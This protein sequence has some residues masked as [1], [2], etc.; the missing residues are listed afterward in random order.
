MTK[1]DLITG[2]LG[3][4]KTT[5]LKHYAGHL[6][7]QGSRVAV[8][9]N[10][11]GAVNADMMMLAELKSAGCML[12]MVAGGGD[13]DCHRRRFK[14]QLISLGMQHFDRVIVEPS[15]IFDMDEFFDLLHESPLDR[16]FEV[17]SVLT[18]A[19][20]TM[21][22]GL[23]GQME[24]LLASQAA[25]CGKLILS[26]TGMLKG[27]A[28]DE[29]AGRVLD[30]INCGLEA[31]KCDR[32]LSTGDIFVK[33]WDKLTDADFS[34]LM[35]AGYR[36]SRYVKLYLPED[37]SSTAHYFMNLSIPADGIAAVLGEIFSDPEC[38]RIYR[39]K[40][41]LPDGCGGWLRVN[42]SPEHTELSPVPEGQAVLT[43]IGDE[44]DRL[45]IDRH[46]RRVNTA[47]D[48]VSI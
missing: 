15:G 26:K 46:F 16:W 39:I 10:D 18:I 41:G 45:A 35:N 2:I 5:L 4:G 9:E 31:I 44:L 28:P 38:G 40:G 17:G 33:D 7:S 47:P 21:K 11:Y 14:T 23:T 37:I 48:F 32:R 29:A 36:G 20:P 12:E 25:C 1:I 19:D 3:S 22:E 34:V 6:L 24:Y 30:R 13:P 8:L 42:A 27:E 43:V